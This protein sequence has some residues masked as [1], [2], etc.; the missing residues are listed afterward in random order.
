MGDALSTSAGRV[1]EAAH[2]PVPLSDSHQ[3][4]ALTFGVSALYLWASSIRK[5]RVSAVHATV[6]MYTTVTVNVTALLL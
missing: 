6:Q 1:P 3:A 5:I 4:E 2:S